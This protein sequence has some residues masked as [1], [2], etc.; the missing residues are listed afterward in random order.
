M[1]TL[2]PVS[3]HWARLELGVAAIVVIRKSWGGGLLSPLSLSSGKTR[4]EKRKILK[5][6][7]KHSTC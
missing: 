5:E 3:G 2:P 7:K 4:V 1:W 6:K